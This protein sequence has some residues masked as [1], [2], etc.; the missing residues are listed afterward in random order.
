ML[1]IHLQKSYPDFL[2]LVD[3]LLVIPCVQCCSY[4]EEFIGI[5]LVSHF[6][7]DE[8]ATSIERDQLLFHKVSLK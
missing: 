5:A 2:R 3:T 7:D 8:V 6:G 1:L 4:V